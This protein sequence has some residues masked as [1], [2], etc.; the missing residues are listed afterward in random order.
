MGVHP[1]CLLGVEPEPSVEHKPEICQVQIGF[2]NTLGRVA[3]R[4][5]QHVAEFVCHDVA[6][7]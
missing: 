2:H 6:E 3:S 4:T 1:R 7:Y 5:K